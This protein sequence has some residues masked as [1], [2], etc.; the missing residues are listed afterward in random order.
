MDNCFGGQTNVPAL[1]IFSDRAWITLPPQVAE[2]RLREH[3]ADIDTD[4]HYVLYD[5]RYTGRF[6][7]ESRAFFVQWH[8]QRKAQLTRVAVVVD[9]AMWRVVVMAMAM[10]SGVNMRPFEV[11]DDAVEWLVPP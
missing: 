2:G 11:L 5:L 1:D 6:D 4:C 10:Q 8:A 9:N 7:D 3:L